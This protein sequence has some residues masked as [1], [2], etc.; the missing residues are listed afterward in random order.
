[1]VPLCA[2]RVTASAQRKG[3]MRSQKEGANSQPGEASEEINLASTLIL[4]FQSLEL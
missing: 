2:E 3:H 1:M 4:D